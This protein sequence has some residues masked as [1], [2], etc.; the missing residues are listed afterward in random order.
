M[1]KS[2]IIKLLLCLILISF[3][4]VDYASGE[5]K[6]NAITWDKTFGGSSDDMGFSIVQTENGGYAIAGY[7]IF[8]RKEKKDD[9]RSKLG[10][11]ILE[12]SKRQDFWIVKLDKNGNMEWDEIFGE[13]MTDVARSIIQTKDGGYAVVG[14]IWTKYVRKQDF[15]LIKLGENGN[16]EWETTFN[17]DEDD[18][19]YSIIQTKDGG[20]TIAGGTGRRFWGEVNCWVIKLDAKGNMEWDNDFGGIGWDEI[21]SIIQT[22][23]GA[24][25]AAGSTWSKGAGRGDV[26]VAKLDRRGY[27]V[28]T[29]TFGGSDYDEAR[30][31]IQTDDGDYAVAGFTISEE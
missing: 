26:C 23:D 9:W 29:K 24:F 10:Y 25:I 1:R 30:S 14:S 28:W 13:E 16:K 3:L 31:I 20:Y 11:I 6:G 17:K 5:N 12:K 15:W 7:A 2:V 22:K 21:Y 8:P 27:L 18:I 4:A 19:A